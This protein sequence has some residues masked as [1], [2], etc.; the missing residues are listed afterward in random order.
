LK[1]A[2]CPRSLAAARSGFA[3]C[4]G[5]PSLRLSIADCRLNFSRTQRALERGGPPQE[6]FDVANLTPLLK[7]ERQATNYRNKSAR[8]AILLF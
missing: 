6:G 2:R 3:F 5:D 7:A 1:L 4:F 8:L